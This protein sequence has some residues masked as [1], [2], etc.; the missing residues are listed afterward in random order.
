MKRLAMIALALPILGAGVA[1]CQLGSSVPALAQFGLPT[2]NIGSSILSG[3]TSAS[4]SADSDATEASSTVPMIYQNTDRKFRFTIPAGWVK[5]QGDP[6]SDSVVFRKGMTSSHFQ[7]HYTGMSPD[8]PAEASVK[9]SLNSAKQD[10]KLG[11]NIEA[12]RRD[13]KCESNPKAL[14]ARGWELI[15]S[16]NSGPQRI[17]WQVYDKNNTY[18]NLMASAEKEEF[19]AARVELQSIINSIKFQ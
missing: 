15:D 8:F 6:N 13:D 14:C 9:A 10:I 11:K 12:K 18:I 1:L 16:G 19:N 5:V 7:F 4:P 3:G 2:G 17:I